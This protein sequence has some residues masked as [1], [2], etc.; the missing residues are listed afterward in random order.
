MQSFTYSILPNWQVEAKITG[1]IND[2]FKLFK[3]LKL[4][5]IEKKKDGKIL[6]KE[7]RRRRE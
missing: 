4:N 7:D 5:P 2:S 3:F 1:I 6:Q